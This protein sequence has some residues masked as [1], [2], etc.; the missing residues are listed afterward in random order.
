MLDGC[1]PASPPS[2]RAHNGFG[3]INL[4]PVRLE[5]KCTSHWVAK[6]VSMYSGLKY[7]GA[8]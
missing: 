4:T 5:L 2:V 3:P 6:N 1:S 7:S 8:P